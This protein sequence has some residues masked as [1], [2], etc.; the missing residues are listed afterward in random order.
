MTAERREFAGWAG[1]SAGCKPRTENGGSGGI[2]VV[3][4][5]LGHDKSSF[6][7]PSRLR[8]FR[9]QMR[10]GQAFGNSCEPSAQNFSNDGGRIAGTVHAKIS[11]LIGRDALGVKR[12]EAGFVL[13]KRTSGHRSAAS[14][15]DFDRRVEPNDRDTRIAEKLRCA[16]LCVGASTKCEN[17]GFAALYRAT[18]CGAKLLG[19]QLTAGWLA[20]TFEELGNGDTGGF[21]DLFVGI[22]QTPAQLLGQA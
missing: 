14:E 13:E 19:F 9:R 1:Q 2:W 18:E 11:E 7:Y 20:I 15:K 22:A 10:F 12:A 6:H 16:L 21:F 8:C 3:A 17:R 5:K 4:V